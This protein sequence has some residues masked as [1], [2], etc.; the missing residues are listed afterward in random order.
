MIHDKGAHGRHYGQDEK[1]VQRTRVGESPH[2]NGR[3]SATQKCDDETLTI[4]RLCRKRAR[5]MPP[6]NV[7]LVLFLVSSVLV[8]NME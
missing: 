8:T 2:Y 6:G 4:Q 5:Q 1:D 3:W 7:T